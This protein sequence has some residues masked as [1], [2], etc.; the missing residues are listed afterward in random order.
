MTAASVGPR[1]GVV[2]VT[3]NSSSV[4][5]GFLESI[6]R[7]VG[8]EFTLYVV[9]N[10]S[11][12]DTVARVR[13]AAANDPRIVV[14]ANPSNRGVAVGN[15]QGSRAALSDGCDTVL[16]LNNDTEFAS[17]LF[18]RLREQIDFLGADMLIPKMCYFEPK[19]M[20]W[21]TG[22]TFVPGQA[23][24]VRHYGDHEIDRGQYDNARRIEYSPTCCMLI[25]RSVFEKIGMMDENYFVYCDDTDFCY[26]A[27]RNGISLWYT[28]EAVLLHKV[29]SLTGG[30][31]DFTI[32]N[33]TRGKAYFIRKHLGIAKFF[34][35]A[36]YQL[37]FF[38]RILSPGYGWKRYRLL[39]KAFWEAMAL[40]LPQK[41]L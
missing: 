25:R 27:W 6:Q 34:W 3:Y 32:L 37:L 19:E 29:S 23:F 17:D 16:L 22:G 33:A 20:L 8:A 40:P 26:R 35:L 30:H 10:A 31:S 15:N 24:G 5:D 39:Q 21:C 36:S 2:T 13:R 1:I 7:Q 14:I 28:P 9:D 18:A 12:D 11:R 38:S 4:W 41:G